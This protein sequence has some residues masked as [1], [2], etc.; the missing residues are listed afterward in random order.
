MMVLSG[1]MWDRSKDPLDQPVQTEQ[2]VPQAWMAQQAQQVPTQQCQ[3]P[4][5]QPVLMEQQVPLE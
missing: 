4:L 1:Q 3:V 2:P 5:D